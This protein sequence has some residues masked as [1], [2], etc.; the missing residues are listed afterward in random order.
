MFRSIHIVA[1]V[2][3]GLVF[4][5]SGLGYGQNYPNK[6]IRIVTS[7]IG[8]STDFVARLIAQGISG[9]LGQHVIV[10]NRGSGIITGQLVMQ[11]PPDGYTLLVAGPT[12]WLAPFLYD[13]LPWDPVRNFTAITLAASSPNILVVHPSVTANSVKELI[14]LAKS[15]PGQLNYASAGAGGSPH[16]S[17]ELFNTM[18]GVNLVRVPY[19]GGGPALNA[20]IAGEVQLQFATATSVTSLVKSG[21]LRALA[22]TS[23]QPSALVP[24]LPPVA[25]TLPGYESTQMTGMFAPA[26]TPATIISRLNQEVVRYLRTAEAKEKL[27]NSGTEAIGSLPEDFAITIK[28]DMARIGNVIKDA[29]IKAD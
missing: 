20:L 19:K 9:P 27:F 2:L 8:G 17:A 18:A 10:D 22:V 24:G 11:A 5:N 23:A 1:I 21:R 12:F 25:A 15:R 14:A 3:S 13:G 26:R 7:A 28:S 29:G 6:S 4:A 16:L